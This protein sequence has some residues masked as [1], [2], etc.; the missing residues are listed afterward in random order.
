[1]PKE[2][3]SLTCRVRI[4][5]TGQHIKPH[6]TQASYTQDSQSPCHLNI[7]SQWY[8]NIQRKNVWIHS[9]FN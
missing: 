2:K 3:P 6:L 5:G 9:F 8:G 4:L 7:F 1:M